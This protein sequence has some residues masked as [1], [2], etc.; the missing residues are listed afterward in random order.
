[1]FTFCIK[2]ESN[3]TNFLQGHL[4][5][6]TLVLEKERSTSYAKETIPEMHDFNSNRF[7]AASLL[8]SDWISKGY[9]IE[10]IEVL[11][12]WYDPQSIFLTGGIRGRNIS[13]NENPSNYK[14]QFS[15]LITKIRVATQDVEIH[16]KLNELLE[17]Y[18]LNN[19]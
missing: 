17:T 2:F 8:I 16:Q 6:A 18:K 12:S 4:K 19:E 15:K 10:A 7:Q 13:E 1:M 5:I 11:K 9:L 3:L 14:A